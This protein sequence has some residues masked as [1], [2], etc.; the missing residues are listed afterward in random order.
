MILQSGRGFSGLCT[1]AALSPTI[2]ITAAH[3]APEGV[4]LA[5]KADVGSG[6]A[7]LL[8][9]DA[10]ARHPLYRAD[11]AALRVKSVD[12]ALLR[13]AAPL[14]S[15]FK[16]LAPAD[17]APQIGERLRILG[18]GIRSES[19]PD[20]VGLL[21][22]GFVAARAPLSQILLWAGD[23]SRGGTGACF[24]DSGAPVLSLDDGRLAAVVDWATGIGDRQCGDITQ[25]ALI[26][27]QR[28][29]IA[30]A[31]AAWAK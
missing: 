3:C 17:K 12:I 14:S 26:A 4:A 30:S 16:I 10:V 7:A 31:R 8:R 19:E 11:A 15:Q 13:L 2:L 28:G 9:V 22:Q 27:P 23:P 21:R 25:A 6:G 29:W 18:F 5:V 24:G 1:G 20:S